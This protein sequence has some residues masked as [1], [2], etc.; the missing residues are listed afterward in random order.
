[1]LSPSG[2]LELTEGRVD[3]AAVN[4]VQ[5]GNWLVLTIVLSYFT[6]LELELDLLGSGYNADLTRD[7]MEVLWT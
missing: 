2:S 1:M 5:W 7:E 4:R 3:A 6:K